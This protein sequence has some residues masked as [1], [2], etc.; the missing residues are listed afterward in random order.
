MPKR[1][2]KL[3]FHAELIRQPVIY[4]LGRQFR[5][6]TNILR[7]NVEMADGWVVLELEGDEQEIDRAVSWLAASGVSIEPASVG[8]S[9]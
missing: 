4:N 3:V 8:T 1:V 9:A 7:A 2:L 6:V 5:V